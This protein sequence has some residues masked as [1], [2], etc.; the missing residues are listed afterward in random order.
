ADGG[1]AQPKDVTGVFAKLKYSMRLTFLCEIKRQSAANPDVRDD[2][3]CNNLEIWFTEKTYSAFHHIC[4]YQHMATAITKSTMSLPRILWTDR[5]NW[6][7]M[8]YQGDRVELG[9]LQHVFVAMEQEMLDL[10]ENKL[11]WN[12]GVRVDT[13]NITENIGNT[14]VG[15]CFLDDPRNSQ[16]QD[17][18]R[19]LH[20]LLTTDNLKSQFLA[21]QGDTY[22]WNHGKLRQWLQ[23][24]AKLQ[25]LYLLRCEMLGGGTERGTEITAMKFRSTALRRVRN[26]S[27]MGKH[28]AL[29]TTYHKTGALSGVDKYIPHSIDSFAADMIIQ[30]LAIARPFAEMAVRICFPDDASLHELYYN[31][32]FVNNLRPWTTESVTTLL[33]Q[34]TLNH[35]GVGLTVNSWRHISIAFRRK[36]CTSALDI[37]EEQEE[38]SIEALSSGHS[39]R[40]ENRTYGISTDTLAG[41]SEDILPLFLDASTDWQLR[42]RVVPGGLMIPYKEAQSAKFQELRSQG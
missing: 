8:L 24:Y 27:V 11:T 7:S 34:L 3:A 13:T 40:Q 10:W 28:L 30:D 14:E 38:E 22:I 33:R 37:D 6:T 19:L 9:K 5:R 20:V 31:H 21:K 32:L 1:H 2:L 42:M 41:P 16:F 23:Y 29:L 26:L 18:M 35:L 15:Y 39:R 12:S 17:R 4:T 25:G 36:L